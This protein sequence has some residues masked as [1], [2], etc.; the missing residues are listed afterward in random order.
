MQPDSLTHSA[1]GLDRL[2]MSSSQYSDFLACESMALAKLN[3]MYQPPETKA[4][5]QG[6]M[7]HA[8]AAGVLDEFLLSTPSFYKQKGGL[9]AEYE[10]VMDMIH[11]LEDDPR[12]ADFLTGT[13]RAVFTAPLAGAEWQVCL[14][15]Y[16]PDLRRIVDIKSTRSIREKVW[17]DSAQSRVSFVESYDYLR[18]AA[19]YAE[20]ERAAGG[21]PSGDWYDTYILAV[22][23]EEPPDKEIIS[24]VDADRYAQELAEIGNRMP[25]ILALKSGTVLPERCE[26][27]PYCRST[28]TLG[29][30]VHYTAL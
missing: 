14:D 1:P 19:V 23:K 26:C 29:E 4:C 25:R 30:G 15:V 8:W 21:R 3:G 5:L 20:V 12:A 27:C 11:A 16:R 24:L 7:L 2:Y 9:Y 17:H 10:T 22:S 28:K 13:K 18:Q 6:K